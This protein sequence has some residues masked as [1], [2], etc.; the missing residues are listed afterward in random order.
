MHQ[1]RLPALLTAIVT[2]VACND[3]VGPRKAVP[4]Q[5]GRPALHTLRWTPS[6]APRT[7]AG[8]S[9]MPGGQP[10]RATPYPPPV[11]STSQLSFWTYTNQ[12]ASAEVFYLA[13][14]STW[15]PYVALSVPSGALLKRPDGTLFGLNDSIQIT[16]TLDTTQMLVDLEPT[17]LVFNP[18][19]P[20]HFT[21]WYSGAD[22]DFNGDGVVD[23]LDAYIEQ[24][25]MGLWV[26]RYPS[27]PWEPVDALQSLL[28]KLLS[29]DLRHFSEYAVSW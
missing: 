10:A 26:R 19:V 29:A 20:A 23:A 5:A 9:S 3:T 27:D 18:L 1:L 13:S 12:D 6:A 14:D 15:Q 24:V 25:L 28:D 8:M 17:G 7:F 21:F 4:P 2:L 11:L 16:I 22:P